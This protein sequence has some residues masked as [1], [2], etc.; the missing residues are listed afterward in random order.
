[1]EWTERP[2]RE[3]HVPLPRLDAPRPRASTNPCGRPATH[4]A[5]SQIKASDSAAIRHALTGTRYGR[6][7]T[8]E[9][10]RAIHCRDAERSP[11]HMRPVTVGASLLVAAAIMGAHISAATAEPP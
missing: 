8:A 2:V 7:R 3:V 9:I 11:C 5:R 4:P 10:R 6:C 1:M